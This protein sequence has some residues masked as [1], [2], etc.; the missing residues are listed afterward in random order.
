MNIFEMLKRSKKAEQHQQDSTTTIT[1]NKKITIS[2]GV[3]F[4]GSVI[5]RDGKDLPHGYGIMKFEDHDVQGL[6]SNGD[7]DGIAYINYHEWMCV[8][9]VCDGKLNGWGIRARRGEVEFGVFEDGE[10][11]VDVTPLVEIYWDEILHKLG[12]TNF[13]MVNARPDNKEIFIG[14]PQL[15][16]DIDGDV[17]F[18][19]LESGD[20]YLG[21][22]DIFDADSKRAITGRF[23]HFD[24]KFNITCGK[25]E[26]SILVEKSD[27]NELATKCHTWVNHAYLDFDIEMN[28]APSSFLFDKKQLY[29]IIELGQTNENLIALANPCRISEDGHSCDWDNSRN[30]DTVWFIFPIDNENIREELEQ[31]YS[32]SEHP[33]I[34]DFEEYKVVFL[35][36]LSED[37]ET[38]MNGEHFAAYKHASC[39]EDDGLYFLDKW[40][41]VDLGEYGLSEQCEEEDLEDDSYLMNSLIPNA[42]GKKWQLESQWRDNGWY[43]TYPSVRDYVQSLAMDDGVVPSF[44][45]WLFDD[46]KMRHSAYWSLTMEQRYAYEQFLKMFADPDDL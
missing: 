7:I 36:D 34:P 25:Y 2:E 13:K 37:N 14:I 46:Y 30:E 24:T 4:E 31:I 1:E 23:L 39:W 5:S 32:D 35:S 26:N 19:F 42:Y 41:D 45:E 33:W 15:T 10:L 22:S 11:K 38:L 28:Y 18:H 29:S 12:E 21:V 17:G 9:R 16:C 6:F 27:K 3:T 43:Y 44:F 20:V 40:D 8:G